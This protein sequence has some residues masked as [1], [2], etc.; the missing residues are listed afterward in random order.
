MATLRVL[1]TVARE[2]EGRSF[3]L[4]AEGT[5]L[6]R[7][8]A[9]RIVI[10]EASVSR[11]HA[12]I[13]VAGSVY[14]LV[15][16]R[17][18]NGT[19]VNGEP[20]KMHRLADGDSVRIGRTTFVFEVGGGAAAAAGESTAAGAAEPL[21]ETCGAPAPTGSRFCPGCGQP[22]PPPPGSTTP[23]PRPE[24]RAPTE[25]MPIVDAGARPGDRPDAASERRGARAAAQ[26]EPTSPGQAPS[27]PPPSGSVAAPG[28]VTAAS[29]TGAGSAPRSRSPWV[30]GCAVLLLLLLATGAAGLYVL[31]RTGRIDL[32][33]LP[34]V[35]EVESAPG[36]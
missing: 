6:G 19:F 5:S 10:P 13:E 25:P 31:H 26:S 36:P 9:N 33:G 3:A 11:R 15:D 27:W 24:S 17:S 22:L 2:L 4:G 30:I 28:A 35:P 14:H 32:P 20:V 12:R 7:D 29:P 34:V 23:T 1:S 18:A 16:Q 8:G 21:C